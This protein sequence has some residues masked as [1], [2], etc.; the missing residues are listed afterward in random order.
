MS[1]SSSWKLR[2]LLKKNFLIMRRNICSTIF[3]IFFPIALILLCYVIRQAFEIKKYY[4]K[5]EEKNIPTYIRNT[6]SLYQS[7]YTAPIPPGNDVDPDLGFTIIPALKICSS[8]NDKKEARPIIASI[9]IPVEIKDRIKSEAG[10]YKNFIEFKDYESIEKMEEY[11]KDKT[12]GKEG[13]KLICFGISFK[14]KGHKYDYSLH[15]FD[16]LFDQGVKDVP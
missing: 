5:D 16:S 11:V 6:S 9:G 13:N 8:L 15:Y 10:D 7:D 12:Y 4:F 2:A 14:Q 3:E 1:S